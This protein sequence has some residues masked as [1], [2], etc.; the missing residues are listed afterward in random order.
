MSAPN[1]SAVMAAV[2]E[3]RRREADAPPP[4]WSVE[5]IGPRVR[6]QFLAPRGSTIGDGIDTALDDFIGADE[7]TPDTAIVVRQS[8]V[9][10]A[11]KQRQENALPAYGN[12]EEDE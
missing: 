11:W 9:W 4:R 6:T 5:V 2:R 8:P 3:E 12:R 10:T 7:W 1:F